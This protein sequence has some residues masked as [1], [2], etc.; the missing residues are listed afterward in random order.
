MG[1]H[2]PELKRRK[3]KNQKVKRKLFMQEWEK[4]VDEPRNEPEINIDEPGS[5]VSNNPVGIDLDVLEMTLCD[6]NAQDEIYSNEYLAAC[7][8]SLM[9]KV[10]HYKLELMSKQQRDI[11]GIRKF[12]Q[13]IAFGESRSGRMVR[14]ALSTSQAAAE[15]MKELEEHLCTHTL[16]S[17]SF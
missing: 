17:H 7:R 6:S 2:S 10:E 14:T 4:N 9:S 8:R 16:H 3:R 11:I 5:V 1:S 13:T 12:Y 15:V